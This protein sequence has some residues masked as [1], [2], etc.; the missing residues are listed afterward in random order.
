LK[1]SISKKMKYCPSLALKG[2]PNGLLRMKNWK[3]AIE[4]A[5]KILCQMKG[6]WYTIRVSKNKNEG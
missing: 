6:L 1:D 3:F 2:Q 5:G 4:S